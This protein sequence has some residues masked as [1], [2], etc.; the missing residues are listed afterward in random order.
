MISIVQTVMVSKIRFFTIA[1]IAVF[2]VGTVVLS[3]GSTTMSLNMLLSDAGVIDMADCHGCGIDTDGDDSGPTCETVCT[4]SFA[5]G[6]GRFDTFN[7]HIAHVVRPLL[8]EHLAGWIDLPEPYP[9][10]AL[11]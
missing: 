8:V 9:P 11:I 5:A 10:R 3:A 7:P 6:L 1:L 4:I 2:A